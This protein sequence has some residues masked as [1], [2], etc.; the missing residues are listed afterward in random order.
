MERRNDTSS[1][2]IITIQVVRKTYRMGPG[3]VLIF[4]GKH[5]SSMN[6]RDPGYLNTDS[7]KNN[8]PIRIIKKVENVP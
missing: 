4:V 6:S 8:Y 3:S 1:T 2:M 7:W 5:S